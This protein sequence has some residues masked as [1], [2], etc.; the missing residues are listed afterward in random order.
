MGWQGAATTRQ[1]DETT[2]HN[3]GFRWRHA[4]DYFVSRKLLQQWCVAEG[5]LPS[6]PPMTTYENGCF[7]EPGNH[8]NSGHSADTTWKSPP[9]APEKFAYTA[10]HGNSDWKSSV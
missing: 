4:K 3:G 5:T 6:I 9:W 8:Q 7:M 10:L 1:H 2:N